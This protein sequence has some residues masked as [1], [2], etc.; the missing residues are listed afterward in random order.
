LQW[1]LHNWNDEG[2]VK[3]LKNCKEA[4]SRNDKGGKI[5]IIDTVII[6]FLSQ[7]RSEFFSP[8]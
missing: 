2:C 5:I 3:I 6:F 4:V 8:K 1:I 7:V